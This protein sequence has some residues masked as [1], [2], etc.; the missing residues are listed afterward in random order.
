VKEHPRLKLFYDA[1]GKRPSAVVPENTCQ[2]EMTT[3]TRKLTEF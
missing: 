3:T 1:F 2:T